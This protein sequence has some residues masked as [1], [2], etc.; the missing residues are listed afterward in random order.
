MCTHWIIGNRRLDIPDALDWFRLTVE[1]EANMSWWYTLECSQWHDVSCK[2][3]LQDSCEEYEE[4]QSCLQCLCKQFFHSS[5]QTVAL[6]EIGHL[7]SISLHAWACAWA[8]AWAWPIWHAI[9]QHMDGIPGSTFESLPFSWRLSHWPF[10]TLRISRCVLI[11]GNKHV[12]ACICISLE[13]L[14]CCTMLDNCCKDFN[15]GVNSL[16]YNQPKEA[17]CRHYP[18]KL[19]V[20]GHSQGKTVKTDFRP[21]EFNQMHNSA[22]NLIIYCTP[23]RQVTADTMVLMMGG[24][25][26]VQICQLKST[27]ISRMNW[28]LAS[29]GLNDCFDIVNED[30][31]LWPKFKFRSPGPAQNVLQ[32]KAHDRMQS[33]RYISLLHLAVIYTGYFA[34]GH[35]LFPATDGFRHGSIP[36]ANKYIS[37]GGCLKTSWAL[38]PNTNKRNS[39][40]LPQITLKKKK[41]LGSLN[42]IIQGKACAFTR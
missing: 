31:L 36:S 3:W 10:L 42:W 4:V 33:I 25:K 6:W 20:Y 34:Y 28:V 11:L 9:K 8:W 14:A 37:G 32:G 30:P 2:A 1:L 16:S 21:Y 35:A 26:A 15:F 23:L 7:S 38:P 41:A 39:N 27:S 19:Y 40:T 29:W 18:Y 17:W 24:K 22:P 12:Y 13:L 5:W